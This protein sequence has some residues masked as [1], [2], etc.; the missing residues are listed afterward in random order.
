MIKKRRKQLIYLFILSDFIA[1]VLSFH[2]AY[3]IR[4]LSGFIAAPKGV[5]DYGKYMVLIP[6]LLLVQ[7]IHFSYQGYYKVKLRRNRLD[8]LFLVLLNTVVSAFLVLLIFSY[9]KSY[10]FI[11]FEVSHVYLIIY[12][13]IAIFFIFGQRL[14]VFLIFRRVNLKRN[15][16]SRV[17]IAGTS[18]LALMTAKNL[19]KYA[20]FGIEITG[21]LAPEPGDQVLGGY[22]DLEAAVKKHRITDIVIALPSSEYLVTQKMIETA[23]NLLI[24]IRLVPDILQMASLKPGMEHIEGIPI[25]NLGEIPLQGWPWSLNGWWI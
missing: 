22:G 12:I 2:V 4:F 21:F 10:Q 5:P 7:V 6:V 16:V 9:F 14:L 15:G 23:N 25:I 1:I 3:W 11:D 13:P 8:D 18:D 24:E 20:H 17:L 19:K